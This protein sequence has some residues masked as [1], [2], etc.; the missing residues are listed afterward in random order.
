[1]KRQPSQCTLAVMSRPDSRRSEE[2]LPAQDGDE[3]ATRRSLGEETEMPVLHLPRRVGVHVVPHGDDERLTASRAL[4]PSMVRTRRLRRLADWLSA[5]VAD[6]GM[7]E[8]F[9][10]ERQ[11]DGELVRRVERRRRLY[12]D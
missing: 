8:R 1:M 2:T 9:A 3:A 12:R 6:H 11:R 5:V 7:S 10:A 4:A